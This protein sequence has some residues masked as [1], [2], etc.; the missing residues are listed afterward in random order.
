MGENDI[1]DHKIE[2]KRD[3]KY[4]DFLNAAQK[5]E[6]GELA[7]NWQFTSVG[8]VMEGFS[9]L[10]EKFYYISILGPEKINIE[11]LRKVLIK[12][13]D[14]VEDKSTVGTNLRRLF[15]IYDYLAFSNSANKV[16]N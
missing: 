8:E 5:K 7:F 14:L 9:N 11:E 10:E 15:R 4:N 1:L 12:Y 13:I 2:K 6:M 16:K 3:L